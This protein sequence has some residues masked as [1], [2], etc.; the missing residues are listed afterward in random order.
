MSLQ[1]LTEPA[2]EQGTYAIDVAFVDDAGA[3]VVP[4]AATWTLTDQRGVVV[5][6][7]DQVA[8]SS[9]ASTI[10]IP[11]S[12]LDLA[13]AP[14]LYLGMRRE[15]LIEFVYSSALGSGLSGKV[16]ATFDIQPL[17]GVP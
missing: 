17:A 6:G 13:Y 10:S 9:L 4:T 8:I 12:G 2:Y 11:L 7:R 5:N 3:P 16:A 1:H 15:V 14:G